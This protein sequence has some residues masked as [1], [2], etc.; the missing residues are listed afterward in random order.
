MTYTKSWRGLHERTGLEPATIT[1]MWENEK[2]RFEVFANS[3]FIGCV[4]P[5][6]EKNKEQICGL[7][8][9]GKNPVSDSWY[10][11]VGE[12]CTIDG[13]GD[14]VGY[15]INMYMGL[16]DSISDAEEG[17]AIIKSDYVNEIK[18]FNNIK[19]ARDFVDENHSQQTKVGDKIM[20]IEFGIVKVWFDTDG[21]E[22]G[23]EPNIIETSAIE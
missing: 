4:Y 22:T 5:F 14:A 18:F 21:N 11:G 1:T 10:D 9:D 20:M 17:M 3:C 19:E 7:L 13:W 12:I 23:F 16:F 6:N 8:D 2:R 15:R